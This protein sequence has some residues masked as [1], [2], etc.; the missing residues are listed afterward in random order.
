[1]FR[2]QIFRQIV[3]AGVCAFTLVTVLS[4]QARA[5]GPKAKTWEQMTV[6]ERLGWSADESKKICPGVTLTSPVPMWMVKI[7]I[8]NKDQ[9]GVRAGIQDRC[10]EA[11][12]EAAATKRAK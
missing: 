10:N 4:C 9:P 11:R 6:D 1:M 8:A 3:F 7:Y 5:A 12:A 2:R